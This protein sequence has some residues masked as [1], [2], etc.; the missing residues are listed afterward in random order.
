MTK[1]GKRSLITIFLALFFVSLLGL[2][3]ACGP[4]EEI[5]SVT[6]KTDETTAAEGVLVTF[7][8]GSVTFDPVATDKNGKAE[9]SLVPGDYTVSLSNTP[10]HY[11]VA[12]GTDVSLSKEKREL[13]I[14]LTENFSYKIKLVNPDGTPYYAER[15]SVGLCVPNGNCKT[16][17]YLEED[18]IARYETA[19]RRDYQV[20]ITGLP[21]GVDFLRN[22]SDSGHENYY[23]GGIV[24][25]DE[26]E[27]TITIYSVVSLNLNK[28]LTDDQKT[29]AEIDTRLD[30]YKFGI[31]MPNGGALVT[32]DSDKNGFKLVYSATNVQIQ[33]YDG[34]RNVILDGG[35]LPRSENGMYYFTATSSTTT[36]AEFIVVSPAATKNEIKGDGRADVSVYKAG[37]RALITFLPQTAGVYTATVKNAQAALIEKVTELDSFAT[38]EGTTFVANASCSIKVSASDLGKA[39]YLAVALPDN[40][41]LSDLPVEIVKTSDLPADTVNKVA[42]TE[43][44]NTYA[45]PEGKVLTPVPYNTAESALVKGSDNYYHYNTADGPLVMVLLTTAANEDRFYTDS[46]LPFVN[47]DLKTDGRSAYVDD[48]VFRYNVTTEADKA[49]PTKGDTFDDYRNFLRGFEGYVKSGSGYEAPTTI[50]DSYAKFVNADGAYPLT[51]ELKAFLKLFCEKN[52]ESVLWGLPVDDSCPEGSEW[53]FPLYYYTDAPASDS[54]DAIVGEYKFVKMTDST[55]ESTT[56][57]DTLRGGGDRYRHLLYPCSKRRRIV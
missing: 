50:A 45:A 22:K 55:G 56:V 23:T 52:A 27:L 47:M 10:K 57:G 9:I 5:Y 39:V 49:D 17:V 7:G 18:G 1:T 34:A 40:A 35:E 24:T 37:A 6:V 13:T 8:Q 42:A 30:A 31:D 25:A 44:F 2:F 28:L 21:A 19:D 36:S 54:A 29:A 15:V 16:P 3:V 26:T 4:K 53:L 46:N 43:T 41:T 11:G 20:Q 38:M 33:E 14:T 12:S 48:G 32:F 51:E